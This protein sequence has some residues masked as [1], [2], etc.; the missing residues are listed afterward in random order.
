M[1]ARRLIL[2]K[3]SQPAIIPT[4][5][6]NQWHLSEAGR[7]R[8]NLLAD[9]LK[10]YQPSAIIGSVEPKARETAEL[11][12][13]RLNGSMRVVEGLHEHER[14]DVG[15]L[16][17][18]ELDARLAELFR[19]PSEIV[20]GKETADHAYARFTE[21]MSRL[22]EKYPMGD[23]VVVSHGTVITLYVSR[24]TRSEPFSFWK[25]LGLPSF[26]VLTLPDFALEKVVE[27]VE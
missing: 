5:P 20:F 9:K 13:S 18:S 27:S 7:A 1:S 4:V 17:E 6:V 2:V 24:I 3:H 11:V 12:A 14:T 10:P 21:T 16:S 8:C 19:K 23:L 26:V 22:I 15:F 25:R